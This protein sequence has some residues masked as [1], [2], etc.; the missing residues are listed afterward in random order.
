MLDPVSPPCPLVPIGVGFD[1]A[2]FGHHVT[3]L[4]AQ[5]N[6]VCPPME[7][8]EAKAGYDSV[9]LCLRTAS[10]SVSA[11]SISTFASMRPANMPPISRPS[12]GSSRL[13]RPF[14]S[15]NRPAIS[16]IGSPFF[17]NARPIPSRVF[18][19]LGSRCSSGLRPPSPRRTGSRLCAKSSRGS[20]G[21]RALSTRLANQLH[22]LLA[23]VF[24]EL[25][26]LISDLQAGWVLQMLQQFPT[27]ALLA[28]ALPEELKAI[29]YFPEE[30][31]RQDPAGRRCVRRQL[32]RRRCGQPGAASG[33]TAQGQRGER[34]RLKKRMAELYGAL[35]TPNHLDSIPGIGVA[36]AA[37]LTAKMVAIERFA[38]PARLVSYFGIFPEEN[39]SGL[40]KDGRPQH[41][42]QAAHVA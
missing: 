16:I 27:P 33:R 21:K 36:T 39:T 5:L 42:P 11:T 20:R 40:D 10:S 2:R 23:R 38:S 9:R 19:P 18:V 31:S 15:A 12:C 30:R 7:F 29:A 4:D 41:R 8:V 24:P 35:P 13:P 14:P 26:P 25:A 37:V 34:S 28:A 32:A 22:N 1:T 17:P 3:F 6:L